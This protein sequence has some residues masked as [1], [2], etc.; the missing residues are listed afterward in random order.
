M[1]DRI[2][3]LD[4]RTA[5]GEL[6]ARAAAAGGRATRVVHAAPDHGFTQ[7]LLALAADREL[8]DHENPGEA[9]LHVLS[10]RMR[11]TAGVDEWELL[12]D[13]HLVIPRRRHRLLALEDSTVLLTIVKARS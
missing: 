6:T 7:L 3:P 2:S 9:L 8:S 4:L 11:L 12:A 13:Q 10:G 1:T 5:V